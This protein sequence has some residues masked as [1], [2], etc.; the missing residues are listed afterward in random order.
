M[1]FPLRRAACAALSALLLADAA[2][3]ARP[4]AAPRRAAHV[5][6][7]VGDIEFSYTDPVTTE[8]WLA[9]MKS[10]HW[11]K[12]AEFHEDDGSGR[13][14]FRQLVFG[15]DR[16][17]AVLRLSLPTDRATELL[18]PGTVALGST[19]PHEETSGLGSTDGWS[20]RCPDLE[21]GT[22]T[23]QVATFAAP[24]ADDPKMPGSM[25][26]PGQETRDYVTHQN[27]LQTDKA[28]VRF[29][30]VDRAARWIEGEAS[31][32]AS[33]IRGRRINPGGVAEVTCDKAD[34]EIVT[35]PFRIRFS[36]P[37]KH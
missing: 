35:L 22:P 12:L 10:D 8:E 3:A 24:T 32:Q 23:L 28:E 6:G 18:R 15:P 19:T 20:G 11:P 14:G 37:M 17:S 1:N 29:T 21:E 33:W 25:V 7:F 5:E 26:P 2:V 31:G 27:R 34:Y 30:S 4:A 13:V 9:Q 16:R 36:I